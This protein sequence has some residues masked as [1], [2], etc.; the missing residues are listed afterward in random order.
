MGSDISLYCSG[1]LNE[2]KDLDP[3]YVANIVLIPKVPH[4]TNMVNIG[5]LVCVMSYTKW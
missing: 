2:C 1:V 3:M 4:P 5:P